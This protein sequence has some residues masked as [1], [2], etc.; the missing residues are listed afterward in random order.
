M[1]TIETPAQIAA[2][3]YWSEFDATNGEQI[4][5]LIEKGVRAGMDAA[6]RDNLVIE[7]LAGVLEDRDNPAAAAWL[8]ENA[9]LASLWDYISAAV[10]VVEAIA[11]QGRRA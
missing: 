5:A 4:R 8:R 1:N 6:K 9:D 11:D 3:I 2:D 7:S 10:D